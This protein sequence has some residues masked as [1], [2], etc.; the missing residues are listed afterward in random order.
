M[1]R[2]FGRFLTALLAAGVLLGATAGQSQAYLGVKG[3]LFMPNDD[4]KGLK[5]FDNGYGGELFF[6]S[7]VGPISLELGGYTTKP[8]SGGDDSLNTVY[9]SGTAKAYLPIGP[10]SIYGG[11]GAGYYY[12]KFGDSDSDS[13]GNGVGFHAVGGAEF[14]AGVISILAE[15]RWNQAK[16]DFG[17]PE[18]VNVGGL[19]LNVGLIF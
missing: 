8:E 3:G 1:G 19:M 7:D 15:V 16:L 9:G 12:S 13:D 5:S 11:G 17:G 6:G 18:D 4:D 14:S 2:T 10:L